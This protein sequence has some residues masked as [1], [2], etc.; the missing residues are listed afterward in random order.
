MASSKLSDFSEPGFPYPIKQA[1]WEHLG[2]TS[3]SLGTGLSLG[4]HYGWIPSVIQSQG[5][6]WEMVSG[7]FKV[8]RAGGDSEVSWKDGFHLTK[9]R[10]SGSE[11]LA[12]GRAG[13][14]SRLCPHLPWGPHTLGVPYVFCVVRPT[15][16]QLFRTLKKWLLGTLG[17]TLTRHWPLSRVLCAYTVI[18]KE[19]T[20]REKAHISRRGPPWPSDRKGLPPVEK[21]PLHSIC[22]VWP[23]RCTGGGTWSSF[24]GAEGDRPMYHCPMFE[25]TVFI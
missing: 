7:C 11:P 4:L 8:L 2:G 18:R 6:G 16:L 12:A 17:P 15:L 19:N 10:D 24:I 14:R 5:K 13:D 22:E 23:L 20:R 9:D 3:G 1:V 21:S 25:K